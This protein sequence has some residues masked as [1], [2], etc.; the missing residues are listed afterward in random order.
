MGNWNHNYY[1]YLTANK[2]NSVLY[3]GMSNSLVT[4]I[5]QH[6]SLQKPGFTSRYK[7]T[8]L[9]YYEYFD[10]VEDAIRREKQLKAGSRAKKEALVNS[11][12]PEWRDLYPDII[13]D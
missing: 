4:R 12:N 9:V 5:A 10:H 13:N 3:T 8:K 6:K 11:M 1:V 2:Y 7:V